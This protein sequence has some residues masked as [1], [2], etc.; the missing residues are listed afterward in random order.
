MKTLIVAKHS[1]LEWDCKTRGLT[2]D[3]AAAEYLTSGANYDT[4]MDSH[5]HQVKVREWFAKHIGPVYMMDHYLA[6]VW[7]IPAYKEGDLIIS[8]GGDNSFTAI[9]HTLNDTPILG[10]NSDP[11]RSYGAMNSFRI[12]H[13]HDVLDLKERLRDHK[14]EVDDWPRIRIAKEGSLVP[15]AT[16][17]VYIGERLRKNMSRYVIN[18]KEY[19]TSGMLVY[20]GA[21]S[22]GW[23][24]AAGIPTAYGHTYPRIGYIHTEA[25]N[26]V[27]DYKGYISKEEPL[28]IQ[29]LCD[30]GIVSADCWEEHQFNRGAR[31]TIGYGNPLKVLFFPGHKLR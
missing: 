5:R 3:A 23:S 14:Y 17:E 31:I 16:S 10:V 27:G 4:I 22:T 8:L 2:P 24:L 21:G 28:T 1:K 25:F 29:S 13:E 30:D 9:S 7:S 6:H 19:K 18:G 26:L 15:L 12:E 20:T 11:K